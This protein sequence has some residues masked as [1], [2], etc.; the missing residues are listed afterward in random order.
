MYLWSLFIA[1]NCFIIII[2]KF[3]VQLY[4]DNLSF[5]EKNFSE[6][7]FRLSRTLSIVKFSDIKL[8]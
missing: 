7:D 1:F 4:Y 8:I 5:S 3:L 6:I 2:N